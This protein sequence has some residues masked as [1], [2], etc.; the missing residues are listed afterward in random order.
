V[1]TEPDAPADARSVLVD[2][3]T[4]SGLV[5]GRFETAASRMQAKY[6]TRAIL[7]HCLDGASLNTRQI[8]ID[9]QK[10]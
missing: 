1:A 2:G 10:L 3:T 6:L 5:E 4:L 9:L 8:L 7:A